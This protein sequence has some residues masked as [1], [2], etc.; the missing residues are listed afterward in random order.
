MLGVAR[1][2]VV[3]ASAAF[4]AYAPV[5]HALN[6]YTGTYRGNDLI[7]NLQTTASYSNILRVNN[8][9]KVL[10]SEI[11]GNDGDLNLQH[12]LVDNLFDLLPVFDMKYGG[13]AVGQYGIHVSGE[14]YLDTTYLGR[15]QNDSPSTYNPYTVNNQHFT[16]ATRNVNGEN[17]ML[18][19]AFVYGE[20]FFGL[21]GQQSASLKVGRQTLLWGQSLYFPENGIANGQAPV[22]L[23]KAGTEPNAQAQQ[24]F[25]PTGQ[26]VATY[27]PN[28]QVNFQAYYQF[29]WKPDYFAGTGSYFGS[30]LL[31][32]GAQRIIIV[33][34]AAYLYHVKD[35]SPPINNGQF[36]AA[37]QGMLGDFDLGIYALRYDSKSPAGAYTGAAMPGGGPQNVA[38]YWF[39]YP[40]D[41]QIYG[42]SFSTDTPN[43][44][45]VAGEISGRRNMNL[46]TGSAPASAYPGSANA[47]ALY[48][49]GNTMAEQISALYT[50]TRLPFDPD[51][52]SFTGEFAMNQLLSVDKNKDLISPGT[53]NMAGAFQAVFSPTYDAVLPN[54]DLTFPIGIKYNLFGNSRV[55]A[56]MV[57]STG[58]VNV[59]IS[60]TYRQT[61]TAGLFYQDYLGK[62]S[63]NSNADR[64]YVS[65]NVQH[66][67]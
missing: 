17:A 60:A 61:W 35:L 5:A 39:V 29:E 36:G 2:S 50:F 16:S 46:V 21:D 67:F 1:G 31:G 43:G 15:T 28:P 7:I 10:T 55:D 38:S 3:A 56:S 27:A 48:P 34:N 30:D 33:P 47:G 66:T 59:G 54:L 9:S 20:R 14:F 22:D 8:P 13:S 40:R 6:L 62:P 45:N 41:I 26:I 24:L 32:P 12:G 57:H 37:V 42:A 44:V 63:M 53:N 18:L 51:G 64:G 52:V 23:N 11:N 58:D 4:F 65:F 49:V 25:L 19:D